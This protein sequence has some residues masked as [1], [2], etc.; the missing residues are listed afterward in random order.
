MKV[1]YVTHCVDMS[2]ANRSLV[3]MMIELRDNHG[4]DPFVVY[5][6]IPRDS[7]RTIRDALQEHGIP[8]V[9]H[10][11]TCFMRK[12]VGGLYK[13]YYIFASVIYFIHLRFLL[14]NQSFDLVHSNSSV[15]DMG[16]FIA[17][18]LHI[19]HIWHFREV[20]SLSF[21]A[22]PILGE[23]Y[24]RYI[25]G[26]SDR[27]I[28]ISK[29]VKQEFGD[30][31]PD[32]RTVVIQNGIVPP[33][34]SRFPNHDAEL[35]N[36]CIVGRV[37]PN[38]NQLE[39]VKA[40]K[41]LNC[42]SLSKVKLHIIGDCAGEYAKEVKQYVSANGLEDHVILYGVR[43]DVD[44]MLQ[45]MNIGLMLSHHEAFGRVTVEYMMHRVCV[46]ASNTS[47]NPEIVHDGRNGLLYNIGDSKELSL[48]IDLLIKNRDLI[49]RLSEDG[50]SD[51]MMNYLSETNSTSVYNLYNALI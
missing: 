5:P 30:L 15:I 43:N 33:K 29:N 32:D 31:I 6:K 7:T 42:E 11:L 40:I 25:Y 16:L 23:R 8:G 41:A 46:I 20:A 22:K 37:E 3:Q 27:I 36:I 13:I 47:A 24:Q 9:S 21:G 10:R 4:I 45:D 2:G 48:K 17:R 19:P 14:R 28:A 26:K 1:L 12:N 34:V 44:T 49:K 39:A 38:K 35:V 50:F 18:S 51:A